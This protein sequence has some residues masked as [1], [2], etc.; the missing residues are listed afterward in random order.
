MDGDVKV[1]LEGPPDTR[2]GLSVTYFDAQG[3][4]TTAENVTL[5]GTPIT[6]DLEDGHAGYRVTASP[7][8][9]TADL[10]LTLTS[11]GATVD[12]D[13]EGTTGEFGLTTFVVE[14]GETRD[15]NLQ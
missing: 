15:V 3:L 8:P 14:G 10:T 13:S 4:S 5:T 2:V 9:T 6:R 1:T 11:D 7:N 12:T